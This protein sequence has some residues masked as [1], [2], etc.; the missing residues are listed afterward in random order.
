MCLRFSDA[1]RASPSATHK[2]SSNVVR[3]A[4]RVTGD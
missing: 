3:V 4:G 1:D 2:L